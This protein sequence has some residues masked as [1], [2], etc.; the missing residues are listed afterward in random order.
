MAWENNHESK[1][2]GFWK[3]V[4]T[5]TKYRHKSVNN[6]KTDYTV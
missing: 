1:Y 2:G 5:V 4:A 3:E 6:L